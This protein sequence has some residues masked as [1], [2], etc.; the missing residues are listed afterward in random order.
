MSKV[1]CPRCGRIQEG[2]EMRI[3]GGRRLLVTSQ[4]PEVVLTGYV[5]RECEKP[6]HWKVSQAETKTEGLIER[7]KP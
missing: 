4:G 2:I 1:K 3:V 6:I 7:A 5:C